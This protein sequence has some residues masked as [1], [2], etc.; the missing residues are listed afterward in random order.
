MRESPWHRERSA[1][2]E[3]G[4]WS[5]DPLQEVH[6]VDVPATGLLDAAGTVDAVHVGID[7]DGEQFVRCDE[8]S[9]CSVEAQKE[10]RK[11]HLVDAV[12]QETDG[13]VLFDLKFKIEGE[14][15]LK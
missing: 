5:Y 3:N 12:A 7:E 13:I 9:L 6:E 1:S 2:C 4:R 14:A 8:V 15:D 10:R 11:I